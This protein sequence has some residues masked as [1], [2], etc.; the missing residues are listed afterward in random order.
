MVR[1]KRAEELA[2][3]VLDFVNVFGFDTDRF[4]ETICRGHKTLQQSV[5]RLFIAVICKMAEIKP[6]ERN[7]A[8]VELAKKIKEIS[9][10]YSL[11]LI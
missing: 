6:D 2:N 10:E 11:P 3:D 9:D 4:A 8:T 5:M 7:R 1:T